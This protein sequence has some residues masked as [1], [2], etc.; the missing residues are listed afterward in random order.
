MLSA[1]RVYHNKPDTPQEF[2]LRA[3]EYFDECASLKKRPLMTGLAYYTG[4]SSTATMRSWAMLPDN[5]DAVKAA[6]TFVAMFY[7]EL[8]T[9]T[10]SS[11]CTFALKNI[12]GWTDKQTVAL[13]TSAEAV[14]P[15][16]AVIL[17]TQRIA[18]M[19]EALQMTGSPAM[20][21]VGA[22]TES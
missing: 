1:I 11:G 15:V 13:E 14:A 18:A 4:F 8:L 2:E 3:H 22:I 9:E 21:V 12:D 5:G 17:H 16:S 10:G 6:I 20:E 19:R 7:E